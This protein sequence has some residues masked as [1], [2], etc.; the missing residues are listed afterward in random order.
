M[1]YKNFI[2]DKVGNFIMKIKI[3]SDGLPG[4]TKV[5]NLETGE[6][7]EDITVID[8][9]IEVDKIATAT[10]CFINVPVEIEGEIK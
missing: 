4:N 7:L 2:P 5:I 1:H 6:E 8:W 9:H 10:L 3:I